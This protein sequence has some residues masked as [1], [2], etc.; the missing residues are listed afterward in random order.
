MI[1]VPNGIDGLTFTNLAIA[2]A[3][4][5]VLMDMYLK[6]MSA[7]K[8]Y[9]EEKH[10]RN[11]PVSS[12]ENKME[13]HEQKLK[14]DYERINSLEEGNRIMMRAMMAMLSHEINGNSVDK[15]AESMDEIEEYLLNR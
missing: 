2:L 9:R 8:A 6:V 1:N 10:R 4:V 14:K 3:V 5:L 15:L 12:L 11:H 13:E 7:I